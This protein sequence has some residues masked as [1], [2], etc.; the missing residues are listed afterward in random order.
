M[1]RRLTDSKPISIE[2]ISKSRKRTILKKYG[3]IFDTIRPKISSKC[4]VIFLKLM[5]KLIS[6]SK[7]NVNSTSYTNN[8]NKI[9]NEKSFK[10]YFIQIDELH[11]TAVGKIRKMHPKLQPKRNLTKMPRFRKQ[12]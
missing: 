3:R 2:F 9:E 5:L 7:L 1:S 10:N 6:N 12:V 4:P 8:G 11:L